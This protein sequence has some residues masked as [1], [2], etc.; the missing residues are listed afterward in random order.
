[1][2]LGSLGAL[3]GAVLGLMLSSFL[4]DTVSPYL[5]EHVLAVIGFIAYLFLSFALAML[6]V[7]GGA[8]LG[9]RLF[10]SYQITA[11]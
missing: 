11:R 9:Y 7:M 1:M 10:K 4:N 5:T 6:F 8:V 2:K 3:A